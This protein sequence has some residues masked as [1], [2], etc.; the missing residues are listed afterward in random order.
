MRALNSTVA[1]CNGSVDGEKFR[2][3]RPTKIVL[4]LVEDCIESGCIPSANIR[5]QQLPLEQWG[6]STRED[7]ERWHQWYRQKR[8]HQIKMCDKVPR[9]VFDAIPYS[10]AFARIRSGDSRS[11]TIENHFLIVLARIQA[12]QETNNE[13]S[14]EHI[15]KKRWKLQEIRHFAWQSHAVTESTLQ[16]NNRIQFFCVI[17]FLR[18]A[19]CAF[20]SRFLLNSNVNV[21]SL[22]MTWATTRH[23]HPVSSLSFVFFCVCNSV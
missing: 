20:A 17:L 6:H 16:S 23:Q 10:Q 19:V 21:C 3:R 18:I 22:A 13:K 2:A 4:V 11:G 1:L 8:P 14:T 7:G 12:T 5:Q 9:H 15:P